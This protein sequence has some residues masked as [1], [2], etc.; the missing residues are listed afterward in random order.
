MDQ[1]V[2]QKRA[3]IIVEFFCEC[4]LFISVHS[5]PGEEFGFSS[6]NVYC[7]ADGASSNMYTAIPASYC[8]DMAKPHYCIAN[9]LNNLDFFS[10]M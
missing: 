6:S 7:I 1:I 3:L 9:I 8:R 2:F 4:S 10:F 5:L